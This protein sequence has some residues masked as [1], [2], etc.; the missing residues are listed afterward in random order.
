M[1][2]FDRKGTHYLIN[3][4]HD[5]FIIQHKTQLIKGTNIRDTLHGHKIPHTSTTKQRTSCQ[6]IIFHK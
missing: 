6:L 1:L 4:N 2:L 5:N 3:K